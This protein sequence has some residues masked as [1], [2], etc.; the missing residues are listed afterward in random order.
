MK[1]HESERIEL[2]EIYT[3]D[4]KKKIV[5]FANTNG[6]IIS[7]YKNTDVG[8]IFE[9]VKGAFRVVLPNVN[10]DTN[11]INLD[12]LSI[13]DERYLPILDPLCKCLSSLLAV[14]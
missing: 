2:K 3:G 1:F 12:N 10:T 9:N 4:I 6:G 8:P 7:S 13:E 5:A 14:L 11:V